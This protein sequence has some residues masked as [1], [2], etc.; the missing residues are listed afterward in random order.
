MKFVLY[1]Y[2]PEDGVP[3]ILYVK[4]VTNGKPVFTKYASDARN[5]HWLQAMFLSVWLSLSWVNAKYL[6]K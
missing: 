6:K 3:T 2:L 5:Y 1:K 4:E